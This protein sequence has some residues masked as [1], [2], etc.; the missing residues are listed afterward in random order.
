MT[1]VAQWRAPRDGDWIDALQK[2]LARA[3]SGS[4]APAP[5]LPTTWTQPLMLMGL[6]SASTTRR[7]VLRCTWIKLMPARAARI[8]FVV[9]RGASDA[10]RHDVFP[11]AIE[12]LLL[13]RQDK[14]SSARIRGISSYSTYSLYAKTMHFLRYAAS[15]PE[16]VIVLGDDDIFVQPIALLTYVWTLLGSSHHGASSPLGSEWYAGRFD[17]YSWRTETMQATA[18]WRALRGAL[19]GA[20]YSFRNCSPSGAGWIYQ[21]KTIVREAAHADPGQERCVGPFAFAKGPLTVL[22]A[23]V[24]R[25]LVASARFAHDTAR[26]ASFASGTKPRGKTVD[27][28]PQDVQMGYWLASHPTLRYVHLPKKT[29]WA[30]AF[31]EVTDLRRLVVAHRVPWDQLAWLTQRTQHLWIRAP[32]VNLQLKCGGPPCPPGQ[33]AHERQQMACAVELLLPPAEAYPRESQRFVTA[34]CASC[35]CWEAEGGRGRSLSGGQCNFSR[36]YV[37][38]LP[39]HCSS[40]WQNVPNARAAGGRSSGYR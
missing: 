1:T 17:W 31:V 36:A 10:D 26:A 13:A 22:S 30:D 20:Q 28:V 34:G 12:E 23:P 11:V 39:G 25:W 40:S 18:Y 14:G 4:G 35:E 38:Q 16:P 21:G 5:R 32:H 3:P 33:C 37:P 8:L 7:D 15:Q 29:G 19:Y 9:G 24:V 27:R 6:V 2:E